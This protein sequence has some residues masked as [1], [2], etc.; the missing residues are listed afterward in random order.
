[1]GAVP[2]GPD[3]L[4][5]KPSCFSTVILSP[6]SVIAWLNSAATAMM[7]PLLPPLR[8]ASKRRRPVELLLA[9]APAACL[10]APA[11]AAAAAA[12]GCG[13]ALVDELLLLLAPPPAFGGCGSA[14]AVALP[15]CFAGAACLGLLVVLLLSA[16]TAAG[17]RWLA[18]G[19]CKACARGAGEAACTVCTAPAEPFELAELGCLWS[20]PACVHT[21]QLVGSMCVG[22]YIT[23]CAARHSQCGK[24]LKDDRTCR[25]ESFNHM[26]M[27]LGCP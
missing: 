1:M 4:H 27:L 10:T 25:A 24:T 16:A 22:V 18:G 8:A 9:E 12:G 26:D 13:V 20:L 2:D 14:E 17:E 5:S 11:A 15:T 6:C 7:T 3:G 23:G 19:F 21:G